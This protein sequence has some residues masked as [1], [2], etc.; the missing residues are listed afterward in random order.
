MRYREKFKDEKQKRIRVVHLDF[1][2]IVKYRIEEYVEV[3]LDKYSNE[4]RRNRIIR[5]EEVLKKI[6]LL[7]DYTQ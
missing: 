1:L 5:K 4:A 6:G 2:A 7:S 3:D